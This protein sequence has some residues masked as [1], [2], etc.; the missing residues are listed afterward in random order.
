[1]GWSVKELR[2]RKALWG[3]LD[4]LGL[5]SFELDGNYRIADLNS[6]VSRQMSYVREDLQG[7]SIFDIMKL[8]AIAETDF[9]PDGA[10]AVEGECLRKDRESFPARVTFVR[11]AGG[12]VCVVENRSEL[13]RLARRSARRSREINTY[14]ALS[15]TLSRGTEPA[16]MSRSVLE[17]LVGVM[18]IDAA[19]LYLIGEAGSLSLCC[20][21]G[22]E[23][24]VFEG[25]R[26]LR[27]YECFIGRVLSSGRS[28]TVKNALEDPRITHLKVTE[29]GFRSIAGVPLMTRNPEGSGEKAIGVL[30]VA[31]RKVGHF[32]SLDMQFL[33]AI[34][35][36]LGVAIENARLLK[37]IQEKMEQIELSHEISSL[38]NS[39][40]S[41]GHIFRL[42]ASEIKKLMDFDRAS[43]T[44]LEESRDAMRIFAL[45]TEMP[46]NLK[47]GV[48]APVEG[49][50][51]SWVTMNQKPWINSEGGHTLNHK[52]APLQGQAAGVAE[53]RQPPAGGL[54]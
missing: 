24:R 39:S 5:P 8:P 9:P 36:Q 48:R 15:R 10:L 6:S 42:V 19:W 35:N 33:S 53:L 45:D 30:G 4:A 13:R 25:A 21:E 11:Q 29:A 1:M 43:I 28:L 14:N 54:L 49:T 26:A 7:S 22:A 34:G 32:S 2:D 3:V 23:E 37:K 40:L 51:A 46:T 16:E 31:S 52:H 27:P 44:L 47:K 41:I 20:S 17:T 38:V 18:E 50:S 12:F